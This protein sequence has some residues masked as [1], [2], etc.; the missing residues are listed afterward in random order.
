VIC[1]DHPFN[2]HVFLRKPLSQADM[3][4]IN[5]GMFIYI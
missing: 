5:R 2:P 3:D 4:L 1:A